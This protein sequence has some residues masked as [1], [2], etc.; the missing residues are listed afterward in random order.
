MLR[1]EAIDASYGRGLVLR[2]ISLEVAAGEV[3]ALLGPNGAGKTTAFR[4]VAGLVRPLQ[5][6]VW[7]GE[8]ALHRLPAWAVARLGIAQVPEGRQLVGALSVW[9]NVALAAHQ[10]AGLRGAALR[11]AVEQALEGFPALRGRWRE[12]ASRLSGGQQQMVA[13]ARALACRPRLLLL[14]EPSLGLAPLA[15][16]AIYA[17]LAREKA[18]GLAMLVIEQ[19]APLALDLADRVY[20]L[21][22]GRIAAE[23]GADRFRAAP[24][25]WTAYLSGTRAVGGGHEG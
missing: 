12:R 17:V 25:L 7:F 20:V 23:G 8:T 2:G 24:A 19:H 5:G 15:V 21:S 13:V 9:D 16:E 3:V 14:D 10:A 11:S 22:N 4:V 18:H 1:L 6:A